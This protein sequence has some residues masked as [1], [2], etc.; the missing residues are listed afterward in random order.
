MLGKC[1]LPPLLVG[2]SNTGMFILSDKFIY[3]LNYSLKGIEFILVFNLKNPLRLLPWMST[4]AY[5]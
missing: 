5:E 4:V 2:P 3:K 1:V